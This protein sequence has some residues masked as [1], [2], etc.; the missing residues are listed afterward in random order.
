MQRKG[1]RAQEAFLDAYRELGTIKEA[2]AV[3]GIHRNMIYYW[4]EVDPEFAPRF[5]GADQD[6][7]DA[8]VAEARRRAMERSDILLMF[9][10]K[11]KDPSFRET[12]KHEH[13]GPGGEPIRITEI[14]VEM[15]AEVMEEV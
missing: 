4:Q 9:L 1:K 3:A 13:T 6:S 7:R 11:Q 2:A 10:I 15:P 5:K 14:V 12:F 8:L